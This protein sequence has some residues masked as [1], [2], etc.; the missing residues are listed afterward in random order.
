MNLIK[1]ILT[2]G[3]DIA[4]LLALVSIP[5]CFVILS[6]YYPAVYP[7]IVR[8][9]ELPWVIPGLVWYGLLFMWTSRHRQTVERYGGQLLVVGFILAN[10]VMGAVL[11]LVNTVPVSDYRMIWD[12]A[13]MMYSGK[14]DAALIPENYYLNI[15]NW[16]LGIAAFQSLVMRIFG[17]EMLVFQIMAVLLVNVTGLLV[18]V[19]TERYFGK[20]AAVVSAVAYL[21]YYPVLVSAGQFSDQHI[22]VP[23][24]MIALILLDS[25]SILRWAMAGLCVAMLNFVRPMGIILLLTAGV[26]LICRAVTLR[27]T[28]AKGVAYYAV[29]YVAMLG[30]NQSM[31]YAGYADR[32]IDSPNLPWFKFDRGLTGF[33]DPIDLDGKPVEQYSEAEKEKV[34]DYVTHRPGDVAKYVVTKMVRYQG[35]FDYKVENTYNHDEKQWNRVPVKQCIFFGWGEYV[36]LGIAGAIGFIGF[37]RRHRGKPYITSWMIFYAGNFAVYFFI[38]AYSGYRYES[39]PFLFILASLCM[40]YDMRNGCG[41]Q[42]C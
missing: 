13:E 12:T 30:F 42:D 21:T 35:D 24:I 19:M 4:I 31:M 10:A 23:F 3:V 39:Y 22:A 16:K 40:G 25:D 7:D 27:R 5:V 26:C 15:F 20:V 9:S 33:Y 1:R 36:A 28:L 18:Y 2:G 34:I 6:F 29:Y 32:P 37:R 14:Y 17:P 11:A 41:E 8:L 38:E